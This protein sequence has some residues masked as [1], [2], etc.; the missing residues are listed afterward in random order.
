ML[1]AITV[2]GYVVPR[3]KF[4]LP[5]SAPSASE[6]ARPE[7]ISPEAT[8][9]TLFQM[10]DQGGADDNPNDVITDRLNDAH[11]LEGKEMTPD[12]QKFAG[13]FWDN[14]RSAPIYDYLRS[15]LTRSATV[16]GSTPAGDSAV[17]SVTAQTFPDG[18]SDWVASSFT[19][20]LTRRGSNWYVTE[21]KS[22]KFPGG[23]YA[24]FKERVSST[25]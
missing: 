10:T 13:L 3:L 7:Q 9:S 4:W 2:A 23:V 12:E 18:G 22:P 15:D 11:L 19:V 21:L 8:V 17:V 20:E 16:A 1:T 25:P 6:P 14:R 24:K 5:S